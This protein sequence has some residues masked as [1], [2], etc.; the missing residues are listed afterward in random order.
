MP[1]AFPDSNPSHVRSGRAT[2]GLVAVGLLAA[3]VAFGA[4]LLRDPLPHFRE[5]RSRLARV[6]S[7][8]PLDSAG[9]RLTTVRVVATS[10]LAVELTVRRPLAD[11]GRLPLAV[12]LGG[13]Y[14]SRRAMRFLGETPGVM[15]ATLSYPYGGDPRPDALTFLRDIPKIRAAFLDTPPAVMLALDYLASLPDVDPT[16]IEAVGVSLGAPFMC[17]AGA[18]DRRFARVWVLHGSGGSYVP[19]EA[20]MKRNIRFAPLRIVAAGLANVIIAGPKL[21][22]VRWVPQ[23]SPRPFVMVN[24]SDDER[25]PRSAVDALY[26]SAR[27]PKEL[28]WMSGGHV[29][30]DK[31]TIQRLVA[32]VM[33]RMKRETGGRR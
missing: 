13:H 12:I 25:L 30:G 7:G 27:E 22:P 31:E 2:R 33:E 1:N 23:I 4:Y 5:R 3:V 32:I 29:H 6:E 11:T 10:G 16:R 18:L 20:N 8:E 28:V 24:A 9:Y 21:D 15:V 26:A 14:G 19:L 17:I